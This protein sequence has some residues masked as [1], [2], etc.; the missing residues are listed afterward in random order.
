MSML[1]L[2]MNGTGYFD[3]QV[4][5]PSPSVAGVYFHNPDGTA[6]Q[7]TGSTVSVNTWYN[8]CAVLS[9]TSIQ[10]YLNGVSLGTA[11]FNTSVWNVTNLYVGRSGQYNNAAFPGYVEDVRVYTAALS[12]Q[13]VNSIYKQNGVLSVQGVMSGQSASPSLAWTFN[14]TLTDSVQ[15]ISMTGT[16]VYTA[17]KY[18]QGLSGGPTLYL[19]GTIPSASNIVTVNGLTVCAWAQMTSGVGGSS[20]INIL[21][22]TSPLI[23]GINS[24][25]FSIILGFFNG[26]KAS[27]YYNDPGNG[28]REYDSSIV[29]TLNTWY[30]LC[31]VF[32]GSSNKTMTFYV[33]GVQQGGAIAYTTDMSGTTAFN[34]VGTQG[35]TN[36]TYTVSDARVYPTA[37]TQ[38]QVQSIY[39]QNGVLITQGSMSPIQF[40]NSPVFSYAYSSQVFSNVGA[41]TSNIGPTQSQ[42][43]T[44]YPSLTLTSNAGIQTWT[45][46]I[47]G[48]YSVTAAGAGGGRSSDGVA[49][50]RG[51]IISTNVLF[52]KGEIISIIVGQTGN[53]QAVQFTSNV[54]GG[55][56][57]GSFVTD[58]TKGV[59][60][61]AAGGGGGASAGSGPNPGYDASYGTSGVQ[62]SPGSN[63]N[64][65]GGTNGQGGLSFV[66]YGAIGNAGG[67]GG[68]YFTSGQVWNAP[69]NF[70]MG[71]GGNG[72]LQGANGGYQSNTAY[73]L[74]LSSFGGFG[75]GGGGGGYITGNNPSVG[76]GGGG[77]GGYS[78]GGGG[79]RQG[80]GGG[81]GGSYV[82]P[83]PYP[84]NQLGYNSSNGF[85]TITYLGPI[86]GS[87][88]TSQ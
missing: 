37:L 59:L 11:S 49:G 73:N 2:L 20:K 85:V 62:G 29:A 26:W 57:G 14:G 58:F 42:L 24:N 21:Y 4:G 67:S 74:A 16:P 34:K 36:N 23:S 76:A 19:T 12:A 18:A 66:N 68:G 61:V 47:S 33:N 88:T 54:G 64:N 78:G 77:G 52:S 22:M 50:A 60:F 35:Y 83:S 56:G 31:V 63:G 41:Y 55:G 65:F 44:G 71:T 30:H 13:Q 82:Y 70:N 79:G 75:G 17:G 8:L 46:P 45:V 87:F 25:P 28:F 27:Y 5:Y 9:G 40:P 3:F 10:A 53:T 43:N 48:V 15:G 72:V 38:A 84:M 51:V 80:G 39:N 7:I 6:G 86:V 1:G 81:G 69:G 32:G